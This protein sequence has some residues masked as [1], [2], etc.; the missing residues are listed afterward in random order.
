MA[1]TLK[2]DENTCIGC[3]LCVTLAP[4]TFRMDE[5]NKAEVINQA[6]DPE[7]KIQEAIDS[8]PVTAIT[9]SEA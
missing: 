1:K 2:I 5:D 6:G 9:Q 7:E 4:K 8:C 3:G